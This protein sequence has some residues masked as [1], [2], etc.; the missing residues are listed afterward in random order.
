MANKVEETYLQAVSL[1][2]EDWIGPIAVSAVYCPPN[3][4]PNK[5]AFT[6]LFKSLGNRFLAGGDYNAKH[7]S[8]GS[9]LTA[10]GRGRILHQVK[11]ELKLDHLSTY[12]PTYWPT[13]H[14]KIPDCLDFFI[15][16][17]FAQGYLDIQS[18]FDIAS[19][20]TPVIA[21]INSSVVLKEKPIT[22]CNN[23]T[24]WDLFRDKI[25]EK[26]N[27][28]ISLKNAKELE[29]AVE[30]F[31][32]LV[33]GAAWESTPT[34]T[35]KQKQVN[36]PLNVREM[37]NEKRRLRNTWQRTRHPDDR[38]RYN[39]A[40]RQLKESVRRL[41][42]KSFTEYLQNLSPSA[43]TNYSLWKATKHLKQPRD[44]IPPIRKSDGTWAKTDGEK[45][46]VFGRYLEE[47]FQPLPPANG[48]NDDEI[49]AFL[50]ENEQ[51]MEP[52]KNFTIQET[53]DVIKNHLDPKK[54][55]GYDLV[56]GQILKELPR[57]AV[58]ML[59]QLFNA[60]LRL[61]YF[62][63][64]WKVAE[65]ILIHKQGKQPN[66]PSSYRPISLLPV[67]SKIM[68]KLLMKRLMETVA[69]K[70]LIP[71]YQFGFRQKHSTV[72]QVHRVVN[73]II[74]AFEDKSYC[75]SAFLDV[76]KAFD[77]VWHEGL[78]YKLKT[79]L[80]TTIYLILKSYLEERYFRVRYE[81]EVTKLR[82]IKSGVPQ[83]SV[84]GPVLYLLFTADLPCT[85]DTVTSTFADDTA[86]LAVN[87]N[88]EVAATTLQ[89]SL[90][91]IATWAR[92]WRITINESK[93]AHITFTKC[94]GE[95]PSITFN[96]ERIPKTDSVKYL[97][98]HLDKHLTWR[99]HIWKKRKQL[100]T[101]WKK[102][103]WLLG[104]K[105]QLSLR[106]KLLAYNTVL[107]PVWTYGIQLWGTASK[108]NI[109]IIERFQSKALRSIV[110]APWFVT[111]RDIYNDLEMPTVTAVTK[112]LSTNYLRRLEQH[113]NTLAINLLDN[114]EETRRL[115]I[116]TPLDLPFQQQ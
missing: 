74:K 21:T 110:D 79:Q 52:I 25:E 76:S 97:G 71:D 87:R 34:T 58:V 2:I 61:K 38:R 108:S 81:N 84:L 1:V 104:R 39:R 37:I 77:K 112:Q 106:N 8:W 6:N 88:P 105:S 7:T 102:L 53:Y 100:D 30:Y 72:E 103:Y 86:I 12:R 42:N 49:Y 18:N 83:G 26:L 29:D 31:T 46:E 75:E 65:I 101:K 4:P 69:A 114:S 68:E 17:G 11:Q 47:V 24:D 94:H 44:Q 116:R 95:T 62:P 10:P 51:Q 99:T 107:K 63:A 35:P 57:K 41:K 32:T 113:P 59:T 5:E 36:C 27:L 14:R 80:P 98:I 96:N 67:L 13:D 82:I 28:A 115:K 70:S 93:S 64:Q 92:K 56:T 19:D 43:D 48:I 50:E 45:V 3:Y 89:T 22:L 23:K 111:N 85:D 16:K 90:N 66:E 9:R 54:A 78:L 33:Q 15:T 73:T 60:V 40:A 55:P 20:H 91:N 109:A